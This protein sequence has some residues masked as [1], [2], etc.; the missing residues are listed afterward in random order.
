MP[1]VA[2][3]ELPAFDRLRA[4]SLPVLDLAEANRPEVGSLHIGI[5]NLMPDAALQATERQFL[6][7]LTAGRKHAYV[8]AHLFTVEGSGRQDAVREHLDNY[9][10]SFSQL[11]QRGLDALVITGANPA[12]PTLHTEWFWEGLTEVMDWANDHVTSTVCSCL[13]THAMVQHYHDTERAKLPHKRWGV[14][15]HR[16]VDP[17]HPLLNGVDAHF[18]APHSHVYEVTEAQLTAAGVRLLAVSEE[19]G[20]HLAVSAD[21]L[22]FVYFQGHP[23]YDSNSLLKEYKRELNRFATGVREDYPPFPEH[24][25]SPAALQQLTT[26]AS[27]MRATT[28][29]EALLAKFPEAEL[30]ANLDNTWTGTGRAMFGNWLDLVH[31]QNRS[32]SPIP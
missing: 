28:D 8:Y 21:G 24:Y 18:D 7:L 3:T 31:K 30:S 1:L 9:Y 14:Y 32:V 6:R 20:V 27:E 4:E 23:E 12:S 10:T 15:P 19:A 5:L 22:R 11:K 13:A 2:H 26:Y 17:G 25:F 16:L 29:R